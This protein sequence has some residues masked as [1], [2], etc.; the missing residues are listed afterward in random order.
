MAN[1]YRTG[2]YDVGSPCICCAKLCCDESIV[3]NRFQ[4]IRQN[5]HARCGWEMKKSL[6]FLI[7]IQG[8]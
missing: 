4:L 6:E 3:K 8:S 7:W 2:P 1:R 5:L